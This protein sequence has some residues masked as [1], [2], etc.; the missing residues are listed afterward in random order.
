[1]HKRLVYIL[2]GTTFSVAFIWTRLW[3]IEGDLAPFDL[4]AYQK[5]DAFYYASL[6]FEWI[7]GAYEPEALKGGLTALP[8]GIFY[9]LCVYFNLALLG[10]NYYGFRL[11][12]VI[13]SLTA[14]LIFSWLMGKRF[15][16]AGFL[17]S[18]TFYL[19][20]FPWFMASLEV[21][22]T[23][24]RIFH[25][26]V[27]IL[28]IILVNDR[29][30]Q[31]WS[32]SALFFTSVLAFS[33]FYFVYP[34]NMFAIAAFI[35]FHIY[36]SIQLGSWKEFL[37]FLEWHTTALSVTTV[38]W[39]VINKI[40]YGGSMLVLG[41]LFSVGDRV[42]GVGASTL[43]SAIHSNL[44]A[45]GLFPLFTSMPGLRWV[46]FLSLIAMAVVTVIPSLRA[47]IGHTAKDDRRS[48]DDI[49]TVF[50]LFALALFF[51]TLFVNDYPTRKMVAALPFVIF[52]ILLLASM[53][54]NRHAVALSAAVVGAM[55]VATN[56]PIV[57]RELFATYSENM[58]RAMISLRVIGDAEVIG[59]YG[60]GFRLYNDTHPYLNIYVYKNSKRNL[61]I[62][63]KAME[64]RLDGV[65]PEYSV[66]I[67]V[68]PQ[69]IETMTERG[70]VYEK[71][72]WAGTEQ[73]VGTVGLF[74]WVGKK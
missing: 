32:A 14:S 56:A 40:A 52:G 18:L 64:G 27:L 70:Y 21:E 44:K 65:S 6:A 38:A 62:Y 29:Q 33:G 12:V 34:T 7:E 1:V 13:I 58:K 35:A 31:E 66:Q 74:R 61:E 17:L 11:N 15:G 10:D 50:S 67:M 43:S 55:V 39:M 72:L 22:P 71:E 54:K 47:L 68:T 59:G 41:M 5:I 51:Q 36:R 23:I 60:Q 63:N 25:V 8:G 46:Y 4:T 45:M 24:Y 3:L 49:T 69:L 2:I 57:Y 53:I 19:V 20:S 28:T 9:N 37:R 30:P 42:A 16:L 73:G 26:A 48:H